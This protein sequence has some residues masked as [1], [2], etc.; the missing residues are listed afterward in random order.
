MQFLRKL[1]RLH[2]EPIGLRVPV[3]LIGPLPPLA[4]QYFLSLS[5][6]RQDAFVGGIDQFFLSRRAGLGSK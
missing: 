1:M 5:E 4:Q 6:F 2:L 3:L